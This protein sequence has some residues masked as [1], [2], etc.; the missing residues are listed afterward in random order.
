MQPKIS[1]I[2][3][4]R[5]RGNWKKAYK[6]VLFLSRLH[7]EPEL[8]E[9]LVSSLWE[10]IKEQFNRNQHEEAKTNIK[11]LFRLTK[12]LNSNCKEIQQEFPPIFRVLGLNTLLPESLRQD[13]NSPEIQIELVDRF[14]VHGENSNDLLPD[15]RDQAILIRNALEK[16]E[17]KLDDE[18][19]ELLRPISFHSPLSE[20]RLFIRG[21]ISYYHKN[22]EKADESWKRL[23]DSRPPYR[24]VGRL[25]KFFTED[26]S[27][28]SSNFVSRF[29]DLFRTKTDSPQI[30]KVEFLNHLRQLDNCIRQ[31]KFKELVGHFQVSRSFLQKTEPQLFERV[32]RTVHSTLVTEAAPDIVRQFIDRNIPLPLDPRGNRT[33]GLISLGHG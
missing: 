31:K 19:L 16:V 3:D 12:N 30:K 17:A 29:F 18:A 4:L 1:K 9:L 2:Q 5:R 21:L 6:E 11:E 27:I 24:I 28:S 7:N 13:M 15:F 10:W 8:Q 14:L 32:F 20:W 22:E 25:R 26:S 23:S 33:L